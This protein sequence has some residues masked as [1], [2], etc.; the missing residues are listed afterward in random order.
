MS[1]KA[2]IV[3]KN[4]VITVPLNETPKVS[5]T[6]KSKMIAGNG[7]F[8]KPGLQYEGEDVKISVN[9]LIGNK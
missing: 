9:A 3:G 7:I 4:L 2:E 6:G 1:M 8:Q 5:S